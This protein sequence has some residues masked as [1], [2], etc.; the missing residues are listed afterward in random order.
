V[1]GDTFRHT[2]ACVSVSVCVCVCVCVKENVQEIL[3][4]C[5]KL[6]VYVWHYVQ[7]H[8]HM[9]VCVCE[10]ERERGKKE[11]MIERL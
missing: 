8:L 11:K 10:R 4:M 2:C 3:R 1:S 7:A 6:C 5:E 9:C